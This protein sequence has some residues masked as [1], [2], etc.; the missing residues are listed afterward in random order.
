MSRNL[1]AFYLVFCV[2]IGL[3]AWTLF[4][5]AGL[6][7]IY[8]DARILELTITTNPLAPA[9]QLWL[10]SNSRDLQIV[11]LIAVVP[12][13]A[14]GGVVAVVGLRVPENPLGD[15]SFQT[16]AMMRRRHWFGRH[17]HIFGRMGKN[18]LLYTSDA[19]DE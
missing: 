11:G 10:Y 18:C 19:A 15:A 9:Q 6:Y 3:A 12:A 1:Q 17:G 7:L 8:G 14:L 5:G 16:M 4:Y 2:V 13:A